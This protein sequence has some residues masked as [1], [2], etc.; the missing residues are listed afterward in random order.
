MLLGALRVPPLVLH[1]SVSSSSQWSREQKEKKNNKEVVARSTEYVHWHIFNKRFFFRTETR[2]SAYIGVFRLFF[3]LVVVLVNKDP[4]IL[5]TVFFFP[6][7]L[8]FFHLV[9]LFT[10]T[11]WAWLFFLRSNFLFFPPLCVSF[12]F[13]PCIALCCLRAAHKCI[14]IHRGVDSLSFLPLAFSYIFPPHCS[15]QTDYW[16]IVIILVGVRA[17]TFSLLKLLLFLFFSFSFFFCFLLP[18][19]TQKRL[20]KSSVLCFPF[21]FFRLIVVWTLC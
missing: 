4:I 5:R 7:C 2:I 3:L 10:L 13:P 21:V 17:I 1:P 15:K 20:P 14:F 16:T 12:F 18:L 19:F 6:S 9:L 11:G 8:L